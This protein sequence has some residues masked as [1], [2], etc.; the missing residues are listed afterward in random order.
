MT[1]PWNDVH[2]Q[3]NVLPIDESFLDTFRK[4]Q[5]NFVTA[6]NWFKT[7][8]QMVLDNSCNTGQFTRLAGLASDLM[9][10]LEQNTEPLVLSQFRIF[11]P[12]GGFYDANVQ[13]L[14]ARSSCLKY[15]RYVRSVYGIGIQD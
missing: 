4:S 11:S 3:F 10:R 7:V 1:Y 13:R 2:T 15:D 14:L 9:G 5:G 6:R 8:D 12:E